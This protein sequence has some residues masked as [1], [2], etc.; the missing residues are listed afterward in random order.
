MRI[1]FTYS[2]SQ[3]Y[4]RAQ[5][6]ADAWRGVGPTLMLTA[7]LAV[8]GA[9]TGLGDANPQSAAFGVAALVVAIL[10]A[11]KARYQFVAAVTVPEL[12][13]RPRTWSITEDALE[14]NTE[15]TSQQW[16]W[17]AVERVE[18]RPEAYL[19]WQGPVMFDLPRAPLSTGQESE[20]QTHLVE[21]GLLRPTAA[22]TRTAPPAT[23][24]AP[25][26]W[27]SHG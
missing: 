24:G 23:D 27:R 21:L 7:M 8:G 2:R 12:W 18:Q 16:R 19:F 4:F 5:L 22:A 14:S 25:E 13:H 17:A 11:L 6:R 20:L 9:V 10:L 3:D 26:R 1:E 15:L